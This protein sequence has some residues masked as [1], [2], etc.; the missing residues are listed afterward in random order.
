MLAGR[1][2]RTYARGAD[3]YRTGPQVR[4][5]L[6]RALASLERA[7]KVVVE[8]TSKRDG[9][10]SALIRTHET[11]RVVLREIGPRKF[12]EVPLSEISA[13]IDRVRTSLP[14]GAEEEVFRRVLQIYGLVRMT[15]QVRERL[16][17]AAT[18]A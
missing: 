2:Y 6:N 12:D 7:E 14:S 9:Y 1:A 17:Q 8:R 3:I 13:L 4:R 15:K 10:V 11:G 16:E 5:C 18:G